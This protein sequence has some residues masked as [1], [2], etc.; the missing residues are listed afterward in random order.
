VSDAIPDGLVA[1]AESVVKAL[2]SIQSAAGPDV[3]RQACAIMIGLATH[4]LLTAHGAQAARDA[5][6]GAWRDLGEAGS[7]AP[8]EITP[9]GLI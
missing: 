1:V 3:A 4:H 5:L 6:A 8:V 7:T 2:G 9:S